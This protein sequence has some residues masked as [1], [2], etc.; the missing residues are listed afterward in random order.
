[1]TDKTDKTESSGG[2]DRRQ[3]DAGRTPTAGNSAAANP[4]AARANGGATTRPSKRRRAKRPGPSEGKNRAARPA[5]H[6]GV[7]DANLG[8]AFSAFRGDLHSPA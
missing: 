3:G 1:M 4:I 7:T 5:L 2:G 6:L 8:A